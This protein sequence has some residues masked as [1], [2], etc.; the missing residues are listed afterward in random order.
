MRDVDPIIEKLTVEN[1][2]LRERIRQMEDAFFSPKPLPRKLGLSG[3]EGRIVSILLKNGA[4]SRDA[5]LLAVYGGARDA[6]D[7]SLLR[8]YISKARRK[9]RAH[10]ITIETRRSYGYSMSKESREKL[11]VIVGDYYG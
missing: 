7:P 1:D 5:I 9:L 8:V 10:G 2:T 11:R 4:A 6:P 3:H